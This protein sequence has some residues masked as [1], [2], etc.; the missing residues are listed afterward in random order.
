MTQSNT[1]TPVGA[2]QPADKPA[3][4]T[5]AEKADWMTRHETTVARMKQGDIDL[6]FVGDSITEWW[7]GPRASKVWL[8]NFT[9][10][11]AVNFGMGGD[12]TQH[13]LWRLQNGG[14]EIAKPRA[15]VL[16]IGTNNTDVDSPAKY[17]VEEV[18]AGIAAIV[19]EIRKRSLQTKV[20]LMAILPRSASADAPIRKKIRDINALIAKLDD[21]NVVRYSDISDKCLNEDGALNQELFWDE[22]HI[23]DNGYQV[24]ADTV[25]PTLIDWLGPPAAEGKEQ[26]NPA[27]VMRS[28]LS[29]GHHV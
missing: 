7:E 27:T 29:G 16:M 6:C 3:P 25:R 8:A 12:C 15:V 13:V 19:G 14:F 10:W 11:K 18:A 17:T 9:G 28:Q 22:V 2:W 1:P 26:D 23:N 5:V 4:R 20:L 24:W 21:G